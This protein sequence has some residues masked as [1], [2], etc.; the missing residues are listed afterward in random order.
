MLRKGVKGGVWL[1]FFFTGTLQ[2]VG[3]NAKVI[4]GKRQNKS[5]LSTKNN[6]NFIFVYKIEIRTVA[7]NLNS[8]IK[9]LIRHWH[10]FD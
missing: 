8:D 10:G 2:S 3:Y 1:L 6:R 7:K 4:N 5:F 9:N